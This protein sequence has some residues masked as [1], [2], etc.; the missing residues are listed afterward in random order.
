MLFIGLRRRGL[1]VPTPGWAGFAARLAV[2]LAAL[3]AALW[4][5]NRGIGWTAMQ[6]DWLLRAAL[7]AGLIGGGAA[8]YGAVLWSLGFRPRDFSGRL[9]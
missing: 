1:Y 8:V 3:A 2:A 6:P 4:L 5:G 7:L 9:Q